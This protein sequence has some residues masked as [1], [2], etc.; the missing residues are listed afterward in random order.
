[1]TKWTIAEIKERLKQDSP[2]TSEEWDAL[3]HDPRKGVQQLVRTYQR[4]LKR[5]QQER[6]RLAAMWEWEN[7]YWKQ[8]YRMIAGVDEAGRG[9]LA[10]PVVAAAVILPPDF[11]VEGMNDSKK[12]TAEERQELR[13]RIEQQAIR[14]GVGV[15]DAEYIDQHNILQATYQAMRIAIQQCQP[16]VDMVLVDAVKIPNIEIPQKGLVKGDQRSHSIAAA[17]IIAKTTR[18]EW[19]EKEAKV[20]PEYGFERHKGYGTAEH[21]AKIKQ[22]GPSPIHRR[23]FAPLREWFPFQ[24]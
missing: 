23:S 21:L 10:G 24:R 9:P 17:S 12:L 14:I 15:V 2:L 22:W 8:G 19:M 3:T 13:K 7:N 5:K 1:M 20:Y 16:L 6:E 18:D 11:H 4:K